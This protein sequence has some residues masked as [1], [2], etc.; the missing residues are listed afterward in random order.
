MWCGNGGKC[1]GVLGLLPKLTVM[2]SERPPLCRSSNEKRKSYMPINELTRNNHKK[3]KLNFNMFKI[4]ACRC[5]RPSYMVRSQAIVMLLSHKDSGVL[6]IWN[7]AKCPAHRLDMPRQIRD[8]S[9]ELAS[10]YI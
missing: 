10:H 6:A 5:P 2:V 3:S 9:C 8:R 1:N 7:W 4:E